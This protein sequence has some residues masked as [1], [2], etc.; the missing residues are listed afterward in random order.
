MHE[1]LA[2]TSINKDKLVLFEDALT[3]YYNYMILSPKTVPVI[4]IVGREYK[5]L[6]KEKAIQHFSIPNFR[7]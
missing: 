3:S 1:N 2:T 6:A 7:L 4:L 5:A